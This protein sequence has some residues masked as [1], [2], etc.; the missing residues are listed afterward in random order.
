[1]LLTDILESELSVVCRNYTYVNVNSIYA[2]WTLLK[3]KKFWE[4][5]TPYFL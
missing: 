5:V 1:M 2:L 4:E 3:D